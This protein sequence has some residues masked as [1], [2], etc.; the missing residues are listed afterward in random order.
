[1]GKSRLL[2]EFSTRHFLIPI[3]LR[4]EYVEDPKRRARHPVFGFPPP[5]HDVRNFLLSPNNVSSQGTAKDN[6]VQDESFSRVC[7][8]LKALFIVT[9]ETISEFD[10]IYEESCTKFRLFMSE[11]QC[12]KSSGPK[13]SNFYYKVVEMAKKVRHESFFSNSV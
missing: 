10:A 4:P 3:N 7:H 1:M 9:A 13:R 11:G 8:F 2:D 5:D 12:M 6:N